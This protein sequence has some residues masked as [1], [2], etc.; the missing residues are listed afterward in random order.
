[1]LLKNS[2]LLFNVVSK[3]CTLIHK[4]WI[5]FISYQFSLCLVV[6]K[7]QKFWQNVKGL[8]GRCVGISE[9]YIFHSFLCVHTWF[10]HGDRVP[11]VQSKW[12]LPYPSLTFPSKS[13]V[14][15]C[16][17]EVSKHN[18]GSAPQLPVN[19][20]LCTNQFRFTMVLLLALLILL[21]MPHFISKNCTGSNSEE[22]VSR[23]SSPC[24]DFSLPG[25]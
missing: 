12:T 11:L 18:M 9:T 17:V 14:Q 22:T 7:V 5:Q 10:H 3:V 24:S 21:R 6:G 15:T 25:N 2:Q 1:M 23:F 13:I 8:T 19:V 20:P 4:C 16:F